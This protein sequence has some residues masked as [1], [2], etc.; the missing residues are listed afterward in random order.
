MRD[1]ELVHTHSHLVPFKCCPIANYCKSFSAS[2]AYI[3]FW[4]LLNLSSENA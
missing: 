2:I 1:A 4:S 3:G